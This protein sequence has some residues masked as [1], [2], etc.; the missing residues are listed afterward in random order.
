MYV[1]GSLPVRGMQVRQACKCSSACL[2]TTCDPNLP[3]PTLTYLLPDG[4][5]LR[6]GQV[7]LCGRAGLQRQEVLLQAVL[8]VL[9]LT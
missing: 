3:F 2:L 4:P 5:A 9:A 1:Y 6:P 7:L 8:Q